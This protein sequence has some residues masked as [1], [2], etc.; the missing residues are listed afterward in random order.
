MP[1]DK[2]N[3]SSNEESETIPTE[4][5]VK[6]KKPKQKKSF[7]KKLFK[8]FLYFFIGFMLL[9]IAILILI[10]TSFFKNWLLQYAIEKVNESL[11]W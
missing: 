3:I 7:W 5:A 10:Q 4:K 2:D 1:D 8:F 6:T 9:L 11:K